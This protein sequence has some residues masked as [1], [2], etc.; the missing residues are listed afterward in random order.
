MTRIDFIAATLITFTTLLLIILLSSCAS[1]QTLHVQEGELNFGVEV[2][3]AGPCVVFEH[4]VQAA[5]SF[6]GVPLMTP[7]IVALCERHDPERWTVFE[8]NGKVYTVFGI[9]CMTAVKGDE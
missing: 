9:R 1:Y 2:P 4:P 7:V 8:A 6:D 3:A 5:C